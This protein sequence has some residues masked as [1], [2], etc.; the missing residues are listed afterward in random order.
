[1]EQERYDNV[2]SELDVR[3]S[4]EQV[5]ECL[6][7]TA[8]VRSPKKR[9]EV[10]ELSTITI[11]YMKNKNHDKREEKQKL[12][13]LFDS[14]CGATLVNKRFLRH[15]KKTINKSTKWSTK[16]GSFKTNKR[17]EIEFT[18]PAF[19]VNRT[20]TCNVY[21]DESNHEASNYD[22][23]IGRDLMHSL[24]INLL[25]DTAEIAWDNAK[26]HMQPPAGRN[27]KDW[28][29]TLEQELLFCNCS[30]NKRCRKNS[31]HH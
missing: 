25:F 17:C 22:M 28:L 26:V 1:V 5:I 16:A 23:I 9:T 4:S 2:K 10:E 30:R 14:G 24:G 21:V 12:R 29:N 7:S 27:I 3:N 18:L 11:A 15:W 8:E 20:I 31:K 13:V 6:V 19:H